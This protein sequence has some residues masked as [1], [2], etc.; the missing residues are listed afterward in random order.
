MLSQW[1]NC[2]FNPNQSPAVG[3]IG[4]LANSFCS[5]SARQGVDCRQKA[6]SDFHNVRLFWE[7]FN[8]QLST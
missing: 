5:K 1:K 4:D 2:W 8:V 3:S 6:V 7:V